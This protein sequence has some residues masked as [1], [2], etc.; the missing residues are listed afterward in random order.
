MTPQ[1]SQRR[2]V[3]T[4]LPEPPRQLY[5]DFYVQRGDVP[6]GPIGELKNGLSADRLSTG[7]FCA[8]ALKML[9]TVAAYALVVLYRQACSAV[10]GVGNADVQTLRSRLWKVPAE[11]VRRAGVVRVSMPGDWEHRQAWEQSLEA[12]RHHAERLQ[13][14]GE[15]PR[16]AQAS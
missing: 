14:V 5:R 16:P 13:R 8:N 11:V 6:E 2:Y 15:P 9:V 10:E 7:G 1:G 3:V 4:N 12:V